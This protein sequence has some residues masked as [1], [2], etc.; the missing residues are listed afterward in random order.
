MR[1]QYL[2]AIFVGCPGTFGQFASPL[3]DLTIAAIRGAK[4]IAVC[5]S[6]L[7]E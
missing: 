5:R 7:F 2:A 3:Q 1:D 4:R 6:G